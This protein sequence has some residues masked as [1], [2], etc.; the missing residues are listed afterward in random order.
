MMKVNVVQVHHPSFIYRLMREAQSTIN[1]RISVMKA[2]A[3]KPISNTTYVPN[4]KY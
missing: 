2:E 1:K 4:T 3:A